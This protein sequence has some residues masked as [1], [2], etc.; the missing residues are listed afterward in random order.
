ML[1]IPLHKKPTRENFPLVTAALLLVNILVFFGFQS[2][3]GR[4]EEEAAGFYQESG[5]AEQEWQWFSEYLEPTDRPHWN[6]KQ[7]IDNLI[8]QGI[9]AEALSGARAR[10]V[11]SHPEFLE[12]VENGRFVERNSK[13]W[14]E[15]ADKRE[16]YE[17]MLEESFTRRHM[18]QYA[19]IEPGDGILHM[20][21]HGSVMHL[22]GN[23][24]FLVLL[25]LLV[26]GALGRGLYLAA[27][28][29]AGL[30]AAG[31]SLAINWGGASGMV[32][33]SGAIAGLM[34][35]YA[36]LYGRRRVRFFYWFFVYFDY[37]K[38]PAIVL[39]PAWLGWELIQFLVSDS[40]V[41]YEAHMG[42]IGAG[43][44]MAAAIRWAGIENEAFLEEDSRRDDDREALQ[45]ARS[46]IADLRPDQAKL[47]VRPL[48]ERHPKDPDVL[49]TWYAA[50]K[51]KADDPE[52][53]NAAARIFDL[54]GDDP[55]TRA[56]IL[57]TLKDYRRKGRM[58]LKPSQ[59]HHL[60]ARLV[61]WGDPASASPLITAL[62]RMKSPP[63]GL[64]NTCLL[65][66]RRLQY[67]E[68]KDAA[69]PWLDQAERLATTTEQRR[70][71]QTLRDL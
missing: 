27:Y 62:L 19:E 71:V 33:A 6:R 26:E 25:G 53:H 49:R 60:A 2:G 15:W 58:R 37:V 11:E 9:P 55:A 54:P 56:L 45:Q 22:F 38:A 64:G 17:S 36:V 65:L 43:A 41:A 40:N 3:D 32:G 46:A 69:R 16:T 39:L 34:G 30:A 10:A 70:A 12:A 21:M 67:S 7:E 20:F 51:L 52:R 50:C 1:I 4:V 44:L 31:L 14:Q 35:L 66:A 63:D 5:L 59:V 47:K 29:V 42:G 57:E 28:L 61:R 23:M 13:E 24:L 48:V 8:E 68:G 18:L